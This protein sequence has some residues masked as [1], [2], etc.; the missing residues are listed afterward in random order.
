MGQS[1]GQSKAGPRLAGFSARVVPVTEIKIPSHLKLR[2][3][4]ADAPRM[5]MAAY[6]GVDTPQCCTGSGRC[7]AHRRRG[8]HVT[9]LGLYRTWC[10]CRVKQRS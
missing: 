1:Y 7:Q 10:F 3:G 9:F 6:Q 4:Q 5:R 8:K 2:K